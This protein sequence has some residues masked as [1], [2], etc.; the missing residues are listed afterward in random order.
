VILGLCVRA[1][2]MLASVPDV[3]ASPRRFRSLSLSL[4]R[5]LRS[6]RPGS[7]ALALVWALL[8]LAYT[9]A[10]A[11]ASANV[12]VENAAA[13]HAYLLAANSFAET[14]LANLPHSLAA[15][16]ATAAQISG[17]CAGVLTNAPPAERE[18]SL[19]LIV[20][21]SPGSPGPSARA[22]AERQR[23]S[24][25]RG[26]LKVELSLALADLGAGPDHEAAQMLVRELMALKWSNAT[27]T[28]ELHLYAEIIA[29]ELDSPVPAVCADMT[30]WVTSGYRTLTPASKAL[31]HR[32]EASLELTLE[33]VALAGRS[34]GQLLP[35]TL[36]P[37]ENAADKAL[38][39]RNGALTAQV[40]QGVE[41]RARIL[42]RLEATVGL[43]AAKPLQVEAQAQKPVVIAR[44]KT[45]AG[46]GFV[47]SAEPLPR[48]QRDA[49]CSVFV[50]ISGPSSPQGEGLLSV[51]S[52]EGTGRCLSRSHV[53]PEPT[54]HCNAGL[55]VVEARLRAA[56][57]SVRLRLSDGR[58]I[59]SPAIRV[60]SRLGGPA[61]LYYQ[62]LRGPSPI[63]VSLTELDA[64]G[65]TLAVLALPAVV[66]CTKHPVKFAPGGDVALVH[67]SLPDGHAFMIRAER[68]RKLGSA[69]FEF[70]LGDGDEELLDGGHFET[71]EEAASDRLSRLGGPTAGTFVPQTSGACKPQPYELVFGLLKAPRDTVLAR[72]S[73]KLEPLRKVAIPARLHAGGV[74]AYGTFSPL[75]TA[76]VIRNA[77]GR[78]IATED[79]SHEAKTNTETCEGEAEG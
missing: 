32:L 68:Y 74:L 51:V 66:E 47:A 36:T 55:L 17:E 38:A 60:P 4:R 6:G 59:T 9:G 73:G 13:T 1:T 29:Q 18:L 35:Q 44:G 8:A 16:E 54:V 2:D 7:L 22:E 63:P 48:S 41:T 69:Y 31:A 64:R 61:G 58:T 20:P 43:P 57:R 46:G 23:Q 42:E 45:A 53:D 52:G 67:G 76:L 15:A 33:L 11:S 37:Y 26:E 28:A 5:R 30:A 34:G 3:W 10:P 78:T 24:R 72:V 71:G 62:A 65:H 25:Q 50:T 77:R 49:G 56:A 39:Q 40:K 14:E 21:G 27:V 12:T 19:G 70:K 79:I 75:P